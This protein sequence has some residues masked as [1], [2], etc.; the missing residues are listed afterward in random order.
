MRLLPVVVFGINGFNIFD[1]TTS[2]SDSFR[3]LCFVASVAG[4]AAAVGMFVANI[5]ISKPDSRPVSKAVGLGIFASYFALLLLYGI[6]IYRLDKLLPGTDFSQATSFALF[7]IAGSL[8]L[9]WGN[10]ALK[11]FSRRHRLNFRAK[12]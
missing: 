5:S 8:V 10:L 12:Q 2:R 1:L 6:L 4:C 9:L 7:A 11:T 3:T